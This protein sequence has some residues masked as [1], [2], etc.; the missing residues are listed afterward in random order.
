[1]EVYVKRPEIKQFEGTEWSMKA[2]GLISDNINSVLAEQGKCNV[3]LTG[4]RSAARLYEAWSDLPAF[5]QMT[6]VSFYFGDE[7]CVPP[8]NSESNYGMAMRTLFSH[9]VPTECSV[10]RMDADAKDLKMVAQRYAELLPDSIEVLLLGVGE[11][12]H[13]AS[14]FPNKAALQ[15][16]KRRVIPITGPKPPFERLTITPP[17][18]AQAKSIFVLANGTVK[19]AVLNIARQAPSNFEELPARLVLSATWL[20]DTALTDNIF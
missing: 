15:E 8:D 1:V 20:L 11:D 14:L 16:R 7:R 18:I 4:G 10:F 3:M 6:G 13:I 9:G 17:V 2:A 5:Q 19:A 12:G